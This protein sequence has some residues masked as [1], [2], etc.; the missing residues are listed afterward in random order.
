MQLALRRY[1]YQNRFHSYDTLLEIV[2]RGLAFNTYP[3][4]SPDFWRLVGRYEQVCG[5]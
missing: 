2:L 1:E 5:R 4:K 3:D